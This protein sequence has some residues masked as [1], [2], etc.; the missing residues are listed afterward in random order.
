MLARLDDAVHRFLK[1]V[2]GGLDAKQLRTLRDLLALVR[3][4]VT[5]PPLEGAA[6]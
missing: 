5:P 3:A 2:L 6:T 1:Q 4:G